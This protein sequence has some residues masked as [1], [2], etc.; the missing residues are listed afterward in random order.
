LDSSSTWLPR[1]SS[2]LGPPDQVTGI[3]VGVWRVSTGGRALVVKVGPSVGDEADGLRQLAK[4]DS[5]PPVPEVVLAPE[6]L[7]VESWVEHGPR[8]HEAE[9]GLGRDLAA[10]HDAPRPAWGGG[11]GWIGACHLDPADARSAADF[12]GTRLCIL[13]ARCGLGAA[14]RPVVDR[15]DELIPPGPPSLVHGDAWWGNVVWG[16]DGRAWLIDPS[17]HGGHPEEDLAMLGLFGPVPQRLLDAYTECRP[18]AEGW[19][20]RVGLFQLYPL[21]VHAVLFGGAYR[22]QVEAIARHFG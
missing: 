11:S 5:G 19:R 17:V 7:L 8:S 1:F 4:V 22:S 9:E 15:L 21:L 3:G 13:A 16:D 6:G 14:I 10:L 18:L 20:Q 12:Y 2:A